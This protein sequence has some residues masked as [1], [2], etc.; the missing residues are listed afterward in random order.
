M[1]STIAHQLL[2]NTQL[3]PEQLSAPLSQLSP[4]Y[5]LGMVFC[6]Q[7]FPQLDVLAMVPP[8]SLCTCLTDKHETLKGLD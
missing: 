5:A 8:S 1:N 6:E 4:I 3:I 7:N 2:S